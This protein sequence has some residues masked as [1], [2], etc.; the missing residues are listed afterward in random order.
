MARG[1]RD[2]LAGTLAGNGFMTECSPLAIDYAPQGPGVERTERRPG[3]LENDAKYNRKTNRW[4]RRPGGKAN[5][6]DPLSRQRARSRPATA[7]HT[8][9]GAGDREGNQSHHRKRKNDDDQGELPSETWK[10]RAVWLP[11]STF[12]LSIR[13]ARKVWNSVAKKRQVSG[14][15]H[16]MPVLVPIN[17]LRHD[18]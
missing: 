16:F 13:Y 18:F 4:T 17:R 11:N 9:N 6:R 12:V 1:K 10:R 2:S 3:L 5:S 8:R 14:R 15:T 7:V